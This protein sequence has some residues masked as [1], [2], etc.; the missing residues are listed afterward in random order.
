MPALAL[1][2]IASALAAPALAL[3]T[4]A[5]PRRGGRA[6]LSE[7]FGGGPPRDPA[8]T[9]WAHAAS[10]GEAAS[11]RRLIERVLA[12]HPG[13]RV[14]LTVHTVTG[15]DA[16]RAW[17]LDRVEARLAPWDVPGAAERVLRAHRPLAHLVI[18]SELWPGRLLAC[19]RRGVPVWMAGAR[20]S[21]RSARG[22][23]RAP[24]AA[25]ALLGP[26]AFLSPQDAASAGRF[27]ALGADP[28]AIGP[29]ET[30]KADLAPA[31]PPPDLPRLRAAFDRD[32][33]V[34]A[35]STHPG[36]EAVALDAFA[37]ARRTDPGLA[38]ILAPRHPRRLAEIEPLV[39]AT[40]LPHAV[41][42]RG[43]APEGAA[44]YVVDTLGELRALY[45]LARLAFVGGSIAPMG[46]HT[47]YEPAWEGCA[48]AHGP[49]VAN[50]APAYAALAEAGAAIRVRDAGELAAAY[51]SPEAGRLAAAARRA[52]WPG[53]EPRVPGIVSRLIAERR[54][55]SA[56][57]GSRGPAAPPAAGRGAS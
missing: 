29:V 18:E 4:A 15:R 26:V 9:L 43:E 24:G 51:L 48:I 25:R 17:G 3:A 23:A 49:D 42:S 14:L 20:L 46:G 10:V 11:A 33:T 7:R 34:M 31:A 47:P 5:S 53:G 30:L 2:R 54:G 28:E 8:P 6:G 41:R 52:L 40:S 21:E 39:A 32:R 13:L 45:G 22:W 12:D 44:V 38:L 19:H 16:A 27:M 55:G 35:A 36:E 57:A 56:D 1:Y 37:A 50:A